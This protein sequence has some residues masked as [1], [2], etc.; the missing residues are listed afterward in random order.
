[1]VMHHSSG[2]IFVN[3]AQRCNGGSILPILRIMLKVEFSIQPG[4]LKPGRARN[5]SLNRRCRD[6]FNNLQMRG[7]LSFDVQEVVTAES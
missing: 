6:Y 5:C 7:L 4:L 2:S 1:M 3:L